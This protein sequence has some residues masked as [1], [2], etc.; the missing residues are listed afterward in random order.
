[1][2]LLQ[3]LKRLRKSIYFIERAFC[4]SSWFGL[5]SE[6]KISEKKLNY[7]NCYATKT[8]GHPPPNWHRK[9]PF[10]TASLPWKPCEFTLL[11]FNTSA[12]PDNRGASKTMRQPEFWENFL[13]WEL[14]LF[15]SWEDLESLVNCRVAEQNSRSCSRTVLDFYLG[16][17]HRSFCL[18]SSFWANS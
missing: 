13:R 2:I 3:I 15:D 5:W 17:E 1:L 14:Y 7:F 11:A 4:R 18:R 6:G 9:I 8:A 10:A 16:L 12:A